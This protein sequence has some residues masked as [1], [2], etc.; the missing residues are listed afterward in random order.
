MVMI[1]VLMKFLF[2]INLKNIKQICKN[3]KLDELTKKYPENI[4]IC[5]WF[6]KKLNNENV[7]I[8]ENTSKQSCLYIAITNKILIA[9]IK[10]TYT[11]IQTIAHECLHAI[12]EK[13]MLKWY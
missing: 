3:E 4:E 11:R 13:R 6:L 10:D 2:D 1:I 7:I 12:Q 8:E 5:K 9:N